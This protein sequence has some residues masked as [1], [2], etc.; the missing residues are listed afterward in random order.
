MEKIAVFTN[1]LVHIN[2]WVLPLNSFYIIKR[3]TYF[4]FDVLLSAMAGNIIPAIATTNAIIAAVIVMEGLKVLNGRI[5]ECK[6][7]HTVVFLR[8]KNFHGC[9]EWD[10]YFVDK[11]TRYYF[12]IK[13]LKHQ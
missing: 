12:S 1:I 7:V 10:P 3:V 6:Q 4:S 2:M 11:C 9:V 13:N 5:G 8:F